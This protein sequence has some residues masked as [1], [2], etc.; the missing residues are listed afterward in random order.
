MDQ[1]KHSAKLEKG[2]FYRGRAREM[3]ALADQVNDDEQRRVMLS[4]AAMY[5][6]L[7]DHFERE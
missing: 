4:I 5:S 3:F 7:A 6:R 1:P 2:R